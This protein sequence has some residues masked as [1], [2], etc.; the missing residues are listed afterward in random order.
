M[1]VIYLMVLAFALLAMG[2]GGVVS[3]KNFVIIILSTEL[4]IAASILASVSFFSSS[5]V[6][7]GSFGIL[8]LSLWSIASVEIIILVAFYIKMKQQVGYFNVNKLDK[9]K[10]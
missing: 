5:Q 7:N 10:W 2:I 8:I 4:I 6:Q 1:L 3:S 9:G